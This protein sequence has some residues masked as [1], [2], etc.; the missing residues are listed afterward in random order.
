MLRNSGKIF[1]KNILFLSSQ[2]VSTKS[3]NAEA[4]FYNWVYSRYQ[5]EHIKMQHLTCEPWV[6]HDALNSSDP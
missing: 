1:E 2:I 5:I 6:V 3:S 4:M